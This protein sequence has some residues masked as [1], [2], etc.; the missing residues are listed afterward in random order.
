MSCPGN[1]DCNV[2]VQS[3]T[4][5]LDAVVNTEEHAIALAKALSACLLIRG[6]QLSVVR[7]LDSKH[8]VAIHT[9]SLSWVGKRLA[10]FESANNKKARTKC[11]K[12]FR[13]LLPLLSSISN[14]DS[15]QM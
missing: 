12:F 5:Y 15:L 8:V 1:A 3:F 14:R 4:L 2:L 7:R 6:A 11:I 13:V 10:A 9:T